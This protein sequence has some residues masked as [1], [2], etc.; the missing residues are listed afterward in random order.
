MKKVLKLMLLVFWLILI[1]MLSAQPAVESEVTSNAVADLIYRFYAL[2]WGSDTMDIAL[3]M[4]RYVPPIR[5]LAH[6]T[7]FAVLGILFYLNFREYGRHP[8]R[9]ALICSLVYA[10]SD[11]IHQLF[12]INRHCS[13]VD[14]LIDGCGAFAGIFLCH[15]VYARW[16]KRN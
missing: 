15:L 2:L 10:I 13:A 8:F 12:V 4:E 11:E 3:F 16:I 9:Y 6:F 7:E 1:F 14:M 5:K